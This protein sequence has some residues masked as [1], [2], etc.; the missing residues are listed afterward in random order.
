M[1]FDDLVRSVLQLC[2]DA[3]LGQDNDGQIVVYTGLTEGENGKVVPMPK[4]VRIKRLASYHMPEHRAGWNHCL[5]MVYE[6]LVEAGVKWEIEL[7]DY[8]EGGK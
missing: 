7:T 5:Q 2:P 4:V 8:N 3:E 1:T 6:A